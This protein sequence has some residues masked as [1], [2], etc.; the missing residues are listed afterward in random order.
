MRQFIPP[1][2]TDIVSN[3]NRDRLYPYQREDGMAR[4]YW[5]VAIASDNCFNRRFTLGEE[6]CLYSAA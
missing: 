6:K 2:N 5:A 1:V 4:A 3:C